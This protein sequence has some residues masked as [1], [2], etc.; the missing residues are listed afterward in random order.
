MMTAP[1][2]TIEGGL[3]GGHT[4]THTNTQCQDGAVKL[5]DVCALL[6]KY[7]GTIHNTKHDHHPQ[8]VAI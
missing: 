3:V 8:I 6:F 4:H 1:P 2:K 5:G 7:R